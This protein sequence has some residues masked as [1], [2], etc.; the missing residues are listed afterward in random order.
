MVVYLSYFSNFVLLG[1][2]LGIGVGFLRARKEPQLFLW[3]PALLALFVGL[4]TVLPV[5]VDRS[6]SDFVFFGVL[7]EKGLP[8][9]FMLPMIFIAV[10]AIMAA[11]AHGA[12]VR[13][14]QF[15]ALDAYRLEITGS[16]LGVLL[17]A[18]IAFAWH[19]TACVGQ[20]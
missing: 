9:W 11:L 10:A 12:A 13:F 18:G 15:A 5:E 8:A 7:Q 1:S 20:P 16:L 14:A 19:L 17:F 6:G 4:V 2:F 3:A